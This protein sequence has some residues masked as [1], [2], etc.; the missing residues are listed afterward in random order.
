LETSLI[1]TG[2]PNIGIKNF[3]NW[4]K[5]FRTLLPRVASMRHSGSAALDLAYVACG[6]TDAYWEPQLQIWDVAAGSLIVREAKGLVAD[7]NAGQDFLENGD[8]V[9]A[10]QGVFNE[11]MTIVKSKLGE[12]S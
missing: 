8:I 2:Y 1:S 9:A 10:N 11:L 7:F 12:K 5:C 4:L 6:R 3:D